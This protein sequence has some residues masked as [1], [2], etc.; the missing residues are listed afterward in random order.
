MTSKLYT[1]EVRG[2]D[3]ISVLRVVAENEHE[4]IEKA[5]AE[6]NVRVKILSERDRGESE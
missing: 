6:R 1:V 5:K 2:F 3:R 4:A